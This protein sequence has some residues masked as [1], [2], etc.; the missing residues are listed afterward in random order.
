MDIETI[1]T[2]IMKEMINIDLVNA[3]RAR[4]MDPEHP[5]LRGTSQNPD[6]YFQGRETVNPYYAQFPSIMQEQ[7]DRFAELTGRKYSIYEYHGDEEAESVIVIMASGAKTVME[8]VDALNAAGEKRG[9]MI[10]RLFNPFDAERFVEAMPKSVKNIAVLDRT[11][12][13]GSA[14]EP[15]YLNIVNAYAENLAAGHVTSMPKIIGGRYG[16]SSKEFTPKMVKAVF[17]ESAKEKPKNHFTVGIIDDVMQTSLELDEHFELEHE[18]AVEALFYGLGSDGTVGANKNSIKIIGEKPNHH[19]QGYFVYD[20]KKSGGMTISHLRFGQSPIRSPYLIESADFIGVHQ[21]VFMLKYDILKNAK[22]GAKILIN[23]PYEPQEVWDRL[24]RIAQEH[25]V[26]KG[27]ELYT[28]NAYEIAKACGLGRRINTIMQTCFFAISRVIDPAEAIEKIKR[29]IEKTYGK[30]GEI[31]VRMNF[32]GVDKALE[33]L[34]KVETPDHPTSGC[35]LLPVYKLDHHDPF[36]EEVTAKLEAMEG[37]SVPVSKIPADGTWPLGTTQYEKRA[38]S[39]EAPIWDPN[40][41]IQCNKCVEVCPHAVIRAKVVDESYLQNAPSAFETVPVKGKGFEKSGRFTIQVSVEDC[42]G[43]ALCVEMCPAKNKSDLSKKAI[44]M[45]PIEPIEKEAVE[46]WNFFLKLP[47]YDRTKLNLEKVKEAQLLR[48]LFEFSG[49]CPGCG[50]TPYVKLLSQLFG[51]RAIIANATGCSSIYGGNLPTTP[52]TKN[53]EGRGPAWNNSLFEDNAEFGLGMRATV[54]KQTNYACDLLKELRQEVGAELA[55]EILANEQRDEAA[56]ARQRALVEKLDERLD[57][58]GSREAKLLKGVCK[59]LIRKSVWS[60]GG[61]GW[62]YD[63]GYGGLDH[64]LAS[65]MNINILVLDTQVYSN[66]GGQTSKAT[67]VGAVAKFS[68]AGKASDPKDLAMMALGYGN[69]YVARV[70]MGAND[71]QTLKAFVEAERYPG[72]SIIIAYS[73]CI[74]H[75][76]DLKY[77]MDHQKMAVESGLWPIFRYD[78]SLIDEGKNPFSLDYKEPKLP[79]K[80]YMY[81]ETRFKMM[82]KMDPERAKRYLEE[83]QRFAEKQWTRYSDLAKTGNLTMPKEKVCD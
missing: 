31:I 76:F 56:L 16:L 3:H 63:I 44:N 73:H 71:T 34:H 66:T 7:M 17:D 4:G 42:T 57:A 53:D 12:E 41:C 81:S 20:S 25:I 68:A 29:S 11:K 75:G 77:G 72:V 59:Y 46:N 62:A 24:P 23:A 10:V 35:D 74:A 15:L 18:G 52:W 83:A 28:I 14:G 45:A 58:I 21:F 43:C 70:A 1:G 64:V 32:C 5:V 50:E 19:V 67:P 27:L 8:T 33:N 55:D 61:D 13:P 82:M 30:K 69:V 6:V 48:P 36:L 39:L 49:A 79:V 26:N 65:G 54:D 51:D 37:D 9:V 60:V 78:P 38:I 22:K 2:D 47:D 40:V 80:E